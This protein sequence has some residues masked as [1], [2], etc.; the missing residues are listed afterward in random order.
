MRSRNLIN[1]AMDH[2]E[3]HTCL[4]FKESS[5]EQRNTPR[6]LF[7]ISETGC[8][9]MVGRQGVLFKGQNVGLTRACIEVKVER[10][11]YM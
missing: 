4:S 9:S 1:A 10:C 8:Y 6:I 5:E 7:T 11:I 2:I 3:E